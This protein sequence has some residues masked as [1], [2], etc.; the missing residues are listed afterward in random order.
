MFISVIRTPA[1]SDLAADLLNTVRDEIRVEQD[2]DSDMISRH[3]ATAV[4]DVEHLAQLALLDQLI[5]L[6]I[7]KPNTGCILRL[8]IGPAKEAQTPSVIRDQE[9]YT[10]FEFVPGIRPCLL[11]NQPSELDDTTT[12]EIIYQAG[13]GS[14]VEDI[15]TDLV[16]A[17]SHQVGAYYDGHFYEPKTRIMSPSL[18]RISS[19]Y[20]GVAL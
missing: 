2:H 20:R 16:Q 13:F 19:R 6:R 4:G 7:V 5:T 12:L 15:P 9:P 18:A 11:W 3:I 17:V 8:P 14:S 1:I 10:A